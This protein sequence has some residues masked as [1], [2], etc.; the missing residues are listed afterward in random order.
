MH[1]ALNDLDSRLFAVIAT[2]SQASGASVIPEKPTAEITKSVAE[3]IS[4][5]LPYAVENS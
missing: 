5:F 3:S 1:L 4:G 2:G